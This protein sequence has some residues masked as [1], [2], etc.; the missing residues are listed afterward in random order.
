MKA[1]TKERHKSNAELE[2]DVESPVGSSAEPSSDDETL[3]DE[4]NRCMAQAL[5]MAES[6]LVNAVHYDAG[7]PM[8]RRR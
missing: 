8:F 1:K 6:K 2:E 4:K 3:S 7:G 5:S